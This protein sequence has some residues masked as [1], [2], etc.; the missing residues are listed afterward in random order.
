MARYDDTDARLLLE[1]LIV[2]GL[3]DGLDDEEV[4]DD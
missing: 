3:L 2:E 4:W 1:M